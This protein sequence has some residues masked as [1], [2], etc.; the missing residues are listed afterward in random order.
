MSDTIYQTEWKIIENLLPAIKNRPFGWYLRN[1]FNTLLS[2]DYF[3]NTLLKVQFLHGIDHC[4][5]L[6]PYWL[7]FGL[8]LIQCR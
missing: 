5:Q 7:P 8:V 3:S 2:I 4:R 6:C 1:I